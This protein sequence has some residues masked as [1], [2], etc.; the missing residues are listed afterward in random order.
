MALA[1]GESLEARLLADIPWASTGKG[2]GPGCGARPC[3]SLSPDIPGGARFARGGRAPSDGGRLSPE[4]RLRGGPVSRVLSGVSPR[5][6]IPLDLRLPAGLKLPTR[7]SGVRRPCG[8]Y[9]RT[10]PSARGPYLALLPVGLAMPVR[11]PVPRW[12]LAPPFHPCPC[13]HGRSRS[14]WRFPSGCPGR[15]LPGTVAVLEPGLSS[16]PCPCRHWP[17]VIR[18]SARGWGYACGAGGST[19]KRRARSSASAAS[20]ASAGPLVQG[21]KRRRKAAS[22]RSGGSAGS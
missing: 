2:R 13:M 14:L 4:A 5:M 16:D 12:A 10:D 22:A 15:V 18:P 3:H 7:A 8:R 6:T 17:A 19:G 20:V 21:R 9:R 11:L 1:S